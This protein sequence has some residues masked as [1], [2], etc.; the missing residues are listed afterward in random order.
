MVLKNINQEIPQWK[1]ILRQN[2][3]RIDQLAEFLELN[4][5]QKKQFINNPKFPLNLPLRLAQK[6]QK[7]TLEDP[8]LK[9]FLPV[10]DDS[11]PSEG[12][13]NDP[14]GDQNARLGPKLLHKYEGR[15][16]LVCTSACAMHCRYCFRQNFD[17]DTVDKTFVNELKMIA[18]DES[19]QEVIL[20]GGDPLSLPDETLN[21]LMI[22]L[23]D[24]PH[25]KHIR[26]HTRFPIGIPERIDEGF[27][28]VIKKIKSQ[29]WFVIHCNH[30]RELDQDICE[31]LRV[32]RHLGCVILNQSVLLKG[33]NDDAQ[34]LIQLSKKLVD[35]GIVPYY[36]HQL[37]RVRGAG[38]F[39]VEED[40]GRS[41]IQEIT[42]CLPGY[43]V[44]KY[45]RE[46][47]GVPNK[48]AL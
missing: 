40:K 7:G 18:Q 6:I 29:V 38:Y 3:T 47:A 31:R 44:P 42:K 11:I 5:E 17:Y 48:T 46:T 34:T 30:P 9:Q 32:L 33:V 13:V 25:I 19:I 22:Q 14:V 26:F 45:V 39:E 43:A 41:L 16:L 8:I 1:K 10:V 27:L 24:I 15:V 12:F 2:I 37:D 35:H 36:L 23:N 20:S 28:E 21:Y 4:E